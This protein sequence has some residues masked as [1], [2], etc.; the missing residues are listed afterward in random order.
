MHWWCRLTAATS[1][2]LSSGLKFRQFFFSRRCDWRISL[3]NSVHPRGLRILQTDNFEIG[4]FPDLAAFK[5]DTTVARKL[6][7]CIVTEEIFGPVRNGGISSTYMY[8][9]K[10]LAKAGHD[11]S[12]LYLK[13]RA[14]EDHTIEYWIEWYAKDGVRLVPMPE[15]DERCS[16]AFWQYRHYSAYRW[17]KSQPEFDV[18]HTSEW[19]GGC[20]YALLAKKQGIAFQNTVFLIKASSPHVWNRHYQMQFLTDQQAFGAMYPEQMCIENGD[21]VIG[22]SAHLL[23]FMEHVGY[24]LPKG[25]T[26]VQPNVIELAHLD[27]ED[28]RAPVKPG[29]VVNYDELAFFGRLET[30]KGL[31]VFCEA[32]DYLVAR[33][34]KPSK[35]SFLGKPGALLSHNNLNSL[36]YL[37][38]RAA[39]WPFEIEVHTGFNQL[40]VISYL[41]AANRI[42]VMPSLIE[43]STMAVYEA[44]IYK[45][46]FIASNAGGTPE[47]VAPEHH[48]EML[49]PARPRDLA[50]GLERALRDG[51]RVGQ[52]SFDNAENLR[53]WSAF[54]DFLAARFETS[55]PAEIVDEMN[56]ENTPRAKGSGPDTSL[57]VCIFH[58]G[59]AEE[60]Q[61]VIDALVAEDKL[62]PDQIVVAVHE[63]GESTQA[64]ADLKQALSVPQGVTLDVISA[65]ERSL[66]EA[67]NLAR[68]RATGNALVFIRSDIHTVYPQASGIYRGAFAHSDASVFTCF[69]DKISEDGHTRIHQIPVGADLAAG[70]IDRN[71]MGC[72]MVAVRADVFDERGGFSD[73][74][75]V[76]GVEHNF[77]FSALNDGV[78]TEIIPEHIVLEDPNKDSLSLNQT[79]AQYLVAKDLIQ[80]QNYPLRRLLL[81]DSVAIA[82]QSASSQSPMYQF[83]LCAL[84]S[85]IRNEEALR[86]AAEGGKRWGKILVKRPWAFEEWMAVRRLNRLDGTES[87]KLSAEALIFLALPS[88]LDGYEEVDR[89]ARAEQSWK[90]V[91]KK[92]PHRLSYAAAVRRL[93]RAHRKR[94]G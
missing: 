10:M 32:L 46:P 57:S 20:Y 38:Q 76:D 8:L 44:L 82:D 1:N 87:S 36:Q 78:K 65:N 90:D 42:A 30:R 12:V 4:P 58:R 49:V 16:G 79:S 83:T 24:T 35:V 91:W 75:G 39:N 62:K 88:G 74:F 50:N 67:F 19:R 18:I 93:K 60:A 15:P 3:T 25:R 64:F 86:I 63:H 41:T 28:K 48:E 26:F 23:R 56:Y 52:C 21:I 66:G 61:K 5:A 84:P 40:Q 72:S 47:L 33:G 51:A 14:V 59:S 13:G 92:K 43:N 11:V 77:V 27:I 17:L 53:V 2:T 89:I 31:E 70:F 54:H 55:G 7:V 73:I 34:V 81:V 69:S 80:T 45:V 29:D 9:A 68:S 94:S 37:E 6:K 85:R 22:G 71:K